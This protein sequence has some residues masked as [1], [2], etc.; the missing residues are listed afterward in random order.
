MKAKIILSDDEIVKSAIHEAG[1]IVMAQAVKIPIVSGEVYAEATAELD[2]SISEI[3]Q[4]VTL[5]NGEVEAGKTMLGVGGGRC[6]LL[7]G[8]S[9]CGGHC[10]IWFTAYL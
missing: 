10:R 1:H 5:D 4:T 9:V 2:V 7:P 6:A 8:R 3:G